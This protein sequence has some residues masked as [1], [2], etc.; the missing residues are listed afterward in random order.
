MLF[1][2]RDG[3]GGWGV[4]DTDKSSVFGGEGKSSKSRTDIVVII[5]EM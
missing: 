1:G 5:N 3:K 4:E 2:E